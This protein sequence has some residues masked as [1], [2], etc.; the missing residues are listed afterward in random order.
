MDKDAPPEVISLPKKL[1]AVQGTWRPHRIARFDGH[2]LLLAKVE[3]EFV[4]HEHRDH[5]EVF[6]PLEGTL[7]V[8]FEGDYSRRVCVGEVLVVPRGVR[9]RPRAEEGVVSI[10]LIDPSGVK[11]TGEEVTERT[12]SDYPE[13]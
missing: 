3:G 6:L 7:V 2:Q 4:W 8:D 13:L 5:D 9:H 11:H 10:L 1:Q 12:I